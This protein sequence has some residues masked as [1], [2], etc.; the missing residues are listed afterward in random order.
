MYLVA[1]KQKYTSLQSGVGGGGTK[2]KKPTK[3]TTTRNHT[4]HYQT[5]VLHIFMSKYTL[6]LDKLNK[7]YPFR[8]RSYKSLQYWNL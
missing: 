2:K 8:K 3:T 5:V 7:A 4:F 1:Y 6:I